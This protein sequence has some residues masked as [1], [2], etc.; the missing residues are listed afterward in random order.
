MIGLG[1][2]IQIGKSTSRAPRHEINTFIKQIDKEMIAFG[3]G[4]L[5][6]NSSSI[7]LE[8]SVYEIN[9]FVRRN[10]QETTGF[11]R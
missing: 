10:D 6:G 4:A 3:Q 1:Q 7:A 11:G 9:T 2:G 8:A 5:I